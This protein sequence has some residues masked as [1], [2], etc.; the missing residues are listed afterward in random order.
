M[1]GVVFVISVESGEVL[2]Y[3]V[4]SKFRFE[5][6]ARGHWDKNGDCYK[7]W[8]LSHENICSINRTSSSESMEKVAAVEMFGQSISLHNLKY[9]YN[10]C[11]RWRLLLIW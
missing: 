4:K 7:S 10:L 8:Y 1:L 9:I 6:K 3:E 5:C 2:D 11:W